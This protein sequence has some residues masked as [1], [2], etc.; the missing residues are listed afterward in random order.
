M[1][2]GC[3]SGT[4]FDTK[5]T[6]DRDKTCLFETYVHLPLRIYLPGDNQMS[7]SGQTFVLLATDM[8]SWR[9]TYVLF[10]TYFCTHQYDFF[11]L[12]RFYACRYRK[13]SSCNELV[14]G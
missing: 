10:G 11:E 7:F 4:I 8:S 3:L 5:N 12:E 13:V 2:S 14:V 9:Q 6:W 1:S